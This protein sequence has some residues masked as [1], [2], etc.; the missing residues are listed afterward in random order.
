MQVYEIF[1]K[2]GPVYLSFQP[3]HCVRPPSRA[4]YYHPSVW[5]NY[6]S[7]G[8]EMERR[9]RSGRQR[10]RPKSRPPMGLRLIGG[11]IGETEL[12]PQKDKSPVT[13]E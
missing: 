6:R 7:A 1:L 4:L 2:C 9:A 3:V 8:A 12:T 5:R 13:L 10:P 11:G